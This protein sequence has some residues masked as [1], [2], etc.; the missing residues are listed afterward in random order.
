LF[1]GA[2]G[3][4][5]ISRLATMSVASFG[6]FTVTNTL[7]I[8]VPTAT[9]VPLASVIASS[10]LAGL[11]PANAVDGD[12]NSYW[13]SAAPSSNQWLQVTFP[14]PVAVSRFQLI[15]PA[16]YGPKS[17]QLFFNGLISYSNTMSSSG[18]WDVIVSP[19]LYATNAY[20]YVY[21][22]YYS[23]ALVSELNFFETTPPGTFADW[24]LQNFSAAQLTNSAFS[25][26]AADPDHDGVFNL[27]EYATISN[28]MV[29]DATNAAINAS[30]LSPGQFSLRFRERND[31]ESVTRQFQTTSTLINNW[32]GVTPVSVNPLGN[33]GEASIHQAVFTIATNSSF[34]RIGYRFK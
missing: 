7:T 18:V 22:S 11:P 19:P 23:W 33:F 8:G 27:V 13:A 6:G 24:Q 10:V 29:S 1:R 5:E 2:F 9:E 26:P 34:Y 25:S 31:M 20:L 17:V 15:A 28:P 3:S 14:R 4:N 30:L 32:M 12:L 16:G 21:N